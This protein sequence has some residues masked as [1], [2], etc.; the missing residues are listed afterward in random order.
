MQNQKSSM[1][2]SSKNVNKNQNQYSEKD[3]W[4]GRVPDELFDE[5]LQKYG[6]AYTPL[7]YNK[8]PSRY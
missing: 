5:Y 2:N 3:Y 8:I 7:D 1:Q 4:E 6:Y